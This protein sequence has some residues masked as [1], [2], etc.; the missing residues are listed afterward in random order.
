MDATE[1]TLSDEVPSDAM[2]NKLGTLP[3]ADT[4]KET[5][6]KAWERP[7]SAVLV[8]T[9][10]NKPSVKTVLDHCKLDGSRITYFV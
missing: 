5:K 8:G 2:E 10:H 1:F 6:W 9:L 3:V 7:N 4:V